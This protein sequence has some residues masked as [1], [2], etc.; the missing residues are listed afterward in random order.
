MRTCPPPALIA[1]RPQENGGVVGQAP[2]LVHELHRLQVIP[3]GREPAVTA[4]HDVLV[5]HHPR[6]ILGVKEGILWVNAPAPHPEHI[7]PRCHARIHHGS[8][9]SGRAPALQLLHGYDVPPPGIHVSPIQLEAHGEVPAALGVQVGGGVRVIHGDQVCSAQAKAAG[10]G[11]GRECPPSGGG[12]VRGEG[13]REGVEGVGQGGP[14]GPPV[15][16]PAPHHRPTP[17][18]V[19]RFRVAE[20]VPWGRERWMLAVPPTAQGS[21]DTSSVPVVGAGAQR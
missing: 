6:L 15:V 17:G 3:H 20:E 18:E 19:V 2:H 12:A 5:N 4:K 7:E 16:M 11:Q 8:D 14:V 9:S 13:G 10:G 21:P 1:G